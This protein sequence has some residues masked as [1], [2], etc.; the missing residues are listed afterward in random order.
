M[1]TAVVAMMAVLLSLGGWGCAFASS[2]PP[3]TPHAVSGNFENCRGC[4]EDGS[5]GAPR[6]DHIKKVECTSCHHPIKP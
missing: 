4:H 5:Q 3:N 2:S 1:K 6:T